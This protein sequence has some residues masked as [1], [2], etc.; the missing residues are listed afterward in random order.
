MVGKAGYERYKRINRIWFADASEV[1]AKDIPA[2]HYAATDDELN[3]AIAAVT[4]HTDR[5]CIVDLTRTALP[6]WRVVIPG[7]EVSY[8]DPS[9]KKK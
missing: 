7:F 2:T 1:F 8:I 4:P 6:V 5:I 3:A 9:R